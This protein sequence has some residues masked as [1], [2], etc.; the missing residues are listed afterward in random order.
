M[1]PA[2]DGRAALDEVF[3]P[4]GGTRVQWDA[5][6]ERGGV[7]RDDRWNGLPVSKAD[8]RFDAAGRV[9]EIAL[10]TSQLLA[11]VRE[12]REPINKI[13]GFREQDWKMTGIGN[14]LSG[15]AENTRCKARYLP[16]DEKYWTYSIQRQGKVAT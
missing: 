1:A 3:N 2:G 11:T 9:V 4:F 16:E 15:A 8:A 10:S 14:F 6:A 5:L 12:I 7:Q 13:C